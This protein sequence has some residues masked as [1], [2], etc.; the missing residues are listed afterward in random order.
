MTLEGL[1]EEYNPIEPSELEQ[2]VVQLRSGDKSVIERIV[3]A[4]LR[5]ALAIASRMKPTNPDLIG[6]ALYQLVDTVHKAERK[7]RDNNITAYINYSL[8]RRLKEY[9]DTDYVVCI[10]DRQLRRCLNKGGKYENIVPRLVQDSQEYIHTLI[11]KSRK[12]TIE[13]TEILFKHAAK[14][15]MEQVILKL[16]S[17][18]YTAA[19][20]GSLVGYSEGYVDKI[21]KRIEKEYSKWE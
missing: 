9:R 15:T 12:L 5:L 3:K 8:R 18:G 20:I 13:S 2:L 19:E 16:K 10:H 4:H 1:G 11:D 7:L 21:I 14:N 6:E 17:K